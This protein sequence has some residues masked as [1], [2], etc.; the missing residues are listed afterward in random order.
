MRSLRQAV[1]HNWGLKLLALAI[2]F[3]LWAVYT[4]EPFA[5]VTYNVSL[6]FVNT[7]AGLD[8]AAVPA[9]VRVRVRG[10]SGLLRRITPSEASISVDLT[11]SAAGDKLVQ[12]TPDVVA[13]PYG[14]TVV[15]INPAQI[16]ISL[17]AS[18]TPPPRSE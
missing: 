13:V 5:E 8:L 9:D 11:G 15:R 14:V 17:I 4:A 16:H 2:S 7:P 1:F 10:R 6:A 12:L 18:S 3:S